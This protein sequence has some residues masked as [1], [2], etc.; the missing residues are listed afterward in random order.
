MIVAHATRPAISLLSLK[1]IAA[2]TW[3]E[4]NKDNVPRLGAATAF[5]TVLSIGPLLLIVISVASLMF[6][7][8]VA[9]KYLLAEI[10]ALIGP[11]AKAAIEIM[12]SST[13][14]EGDGIVASLI[15]VATLLVS[16][17]GFF[18][19]IQDSLNTIWNVTPEKF[20]ILDFVKKRVLSFALVIGIGLLLLVALVISAVL[21][22]LGDSFAYAVHPSILQLIN[23]V[24]SLSVITVLFA[25]M[26]KVLPDAHVLWRDVLVGAGLTALLFSIGKQLIGVYLGQSAL[27]SAYGAAG[28][29]LVVLIWVYYSTQIFFLG[30]EFTQVYSRFMAGQ[31]VMDSHESEPVNVAKKKPVNEST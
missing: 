1:F 21:A 31:I 18:A 9:R 4:W 29:L 24:I 2:Q 25:V 22:A 7:E 16:A 10:G 8:A 27:S 5:Y 28:S 6:E 13:Q 26:F 3:R 15:G 23:L 17:T 14:S 19:Q 20:G 11:R 12:L 30:A